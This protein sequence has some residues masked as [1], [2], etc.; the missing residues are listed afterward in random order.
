MIEKKKQ[1]E[2]NYKLSKETLFNFLQEGYNE[3]KII[4]ETTNRHQSNEK[5]K[6]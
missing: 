2:T 5:E 4:E 6:K 1:L 3:F